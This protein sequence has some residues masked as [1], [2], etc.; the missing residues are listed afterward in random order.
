MS[1]SRSGWLAR[2]NPP[3]FSSMNREAGIGG[4]EVG[5]IVDSGVFV[6]GGVGVAVGSWIF[7][8]E[9]ALNR[10]MLIHS[11]KITFFIIDLYSLT[12]S[13]T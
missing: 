13:M 4:M 8:A 9:Q 11:W 3:L 6:E 1:K 5:V 7:E 12:D 2:E 10:I